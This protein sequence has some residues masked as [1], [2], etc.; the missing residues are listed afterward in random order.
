MLSYLC[1]F[2]GLIKE[3]E[4]MRNVIMVALL[5]ICAGVCATAQQTSCSIDDFAKGVF[6]E[7]ASF[8]TDEYLGRIKVYDDTMTHVT[9]NLAKDFAVIAKTNSEGLTAV[10]GLVGG[11]HVETG[12][13]VVVDENSKYTYGVMAGNGVYNAS[14]EREKAFIKD[15]RYTSDGE[16]AYLYR[17]S[18]EEIDANIYFSISEFDYECGDEDA[19]EYVLYNPKEFDEDGNIDVTIRRFRRIVKYE[20]DAL[21]DFLFEKKSLLG[22][23][24]RAYDVHGNAVAIL[25]K[26][27]SQWQIDE[28]KRTATFTPILPYKFDSNV[29]PDWYLDGYI[30]AIEAE[31]VSLAIDIENKSVL[32]SVDDANSATPR[33]AAIDGGI[34]I[35]G[36]DGCGVDV[37]SVDGEKV[38][39]GR[40]PQVCLPSGLYI[41]RVDG[42]ALKVVVR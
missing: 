32:T 3:K 28:T 18:K 20:V 12:D 34:A 6:G 9:G 7:S 11:L 27:E 8:S 5:L 39:S 40:G 22:I 21:P 4:I 29:K 33:V 41:V 16:L 42:L 10:I 19:E 31:G 23:N 38:Y 25:N 30:K 26:L 37:Y 13:I 35:S 36:C 14:F 24:V 15:F 1:S 2:N 17:F